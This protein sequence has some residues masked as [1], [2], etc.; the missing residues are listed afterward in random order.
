MP[1]VYKVVQVTKGGNLRSFVINWYRGVFCRRYA[2]GKRTFPPKAFPD[3]W[4]MAFQTLEQAKRFFKGFPGGQIYEAEATKVRDA[5]NT[6]ISDLSGDADE[7]WRWWLRQEGYS[8]CPPEGTVFC[9]DITLTRLVY[10]PPKG[11][12]A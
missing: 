4:L 9:S 5:D 8:H 6:R 1:T 7:L 11:S 2:V 3:A 10:D 12:E